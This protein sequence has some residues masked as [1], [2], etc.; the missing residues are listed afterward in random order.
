VTQNEIKESNEK[1]INFF[2]DIVGDLLEKDINPKL[3]IYSLTFVAAE[4]GFLSAQ[5]KQDV[6]PFL[7]DSI[8]NAS[9][10]INEEK[11]ISDIHVETKEEIIERGDE[12]LHK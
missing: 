12:T 8:V 2:R 7:L 3:I 5:N 10:L 9:N 6:Y 11:L 1:V 4:L